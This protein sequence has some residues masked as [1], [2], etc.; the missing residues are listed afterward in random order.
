VLA[1]A[2][3]AFATLAVAVAYG[4]VEVPQPDTEYTPVSKSAGPIW[5]QV[6]GA[7]FPRTSVSESSPT[8]FQLD[9]FAVA[10]ANQSNG[11]AGGAE[12][13][14]RGEDV[15]TCERVPVIYQYS[16]RFG[17][18]RWE[19]IYR[20]DEKGFVGAIAWTA[21]GGAIAVGGT[22]EYTRQE[23]AAGAAELAGL[24]RVWTFDGDGWQ[25]DEALPA[26]TDGGKPMA[27]LTAV[28][29]SPR[30]ERFCVAGGLR[31]LWH[32]RGDR[33][34][35]SYEQTSPSDRFDDAASF[36]FRVRQIAFAPGATAPSSTP[37]VVAVTSGCCSAEAMQN[38][39]RLLMLQKGKWHSRLL[40]NDY[41]TTRPAGEPP[42]QADAASRSTT[43]DARGTQS[44]P[45]SYFSVVFQGS[46]SNRVSVLAAPARYDGDA[47]RQSSRVIGPVQLENAAQSM[48]VST[49]PTGLS[50]TVVGAAGGQSGP[51][52]DTA[53]SA[54]SVAETGSP[55]SPGLGGDLVN[56]VMTAELSDVRLVAGD[57]D[58]ASTQGRT[59]L[60]TVPTP[61][62]DG[63]LDWAVGG[64]PN[65]RGAAYTTTEGS[66]PLSDVLDCRGADNLAQYAG[67]NALGV[68]TC[69]AKGTDGAGKEL[70]SQRLVYLESYTLNAFDYEPLGAVAWAAGDR[71]ALV[72]FGGDGKLRSTAQPNLPE[73]GPP[74]PIAPADTSAYE[75]FRP[76]APEGAVGPVPP[77]KDRPLNHFAGLRLV[78]DGVPDPTRRRFGDPRENLSDI[79]MSRDGSEGWALGTADLA[80]NGVAL[81]HYDGE[82]WARCDPSGIADRLEADPACAAWAPLQ[83]QGASLRAAARVP[84]ERDESE[85]DDDDE[86][87]AVALVAAY[88]RP[89][90]T[91]GPA[92][93]RYRQGSWEVD[94]AMANGL[95]AQLS[96]STAPSLVFLAPNDG[97]LLGYFGRTVQLLH[98]DGEGWVD[99]STDPARTDECGDTSTGRLPLEGVAN[100]GL[101]LTRAGDRLYLYA[102]R[103]A[104]GSTAA[105]HP[106]ASGLLPVTVPL[107]LHK[108][109]GEEWQAEPGGDPAAENAGSGSQTIGRV[110]DVSIIKRGDGYVGW[111][112]GRFGGND[113]EERTSQVD[114]AR[115]AIGTATPLLRLEGGRWQ[116]VADAGAARD[117]V[118]RSAFGRHEILTI[119]GPGDKEHAILYPVHGTGQPQHPA[120][121]YREG[122]GWD[123]LPAPFVQKSKGEGTPQTVQAGVRAVA[124]DGRDGAW[125]VGVQ[126]VVPGT[127]TQSDEVPQPHQAPFFYRYADEQNVPVFDEAPHPV[128][129]PITATA[130]SPDGTLWVATASSTVYRYDRMTGWQRIAVGGW[131]PSI[132]RA[133]EANA[134]AVGPDGKGLIVGR[135]GRIAAVSP[136]T[137]VLDVAAGRGC[138]AGA[139]PCSTPHDLRAVAIATDGSAMAGGDG[140]SLL[141]R[142][143]SG[144]FRAVNT[145]RTAPTARI[146]SVVLPTPAQAFVA[147][148]LGEVFVGTLSGNDWDWQLENVDARDNLISLGQG[149]TAI[150]LRALAVDKDGRGYA[151]GEKGLILKRDPGAERPWQRLDLPYTDNFYSVA[152][153]P[154]GS[155]KALVGGGLGL[156]LTGSGDRFAVAR[157]S[158]YYDPLTTSHGSALAARIVGVALLRGPQPG[159]LE[160]WAASQVPPAA[161]ASRTPEPGAMLHYTNAP[162]EPLL[163]PARRTEPLP[164][165]P[166]ERPGELVF[167]AFGRGECHYERGTCPEPA[168]T[169][170]FN[171]VVTR[172]VIDELAADEQ[173]GPKPDFALI[174]GDIASAAGRESGATEGTGTGVSVNTPLDDDIMHRR[175]VEAFGSRLRDAGMPTFA[176]IGGKDLGPADACAAALARCHGTRHDGQG[177]GLSH[178]WRQAFAGM[179]EPWGTVDEQQTRDDL[180][181]VPVP[182]DSIEPLEAPGG[183]AKTHYAVDVKRGGQAVARIVVVDTSLR[184]LAAGEATQNPIEPRGGQSLWLERALCFRDETV[185]GGACSRDRAQQAIVLSNTPSYSYGPGANEDTL[186][187]FATFETTLMRYKTT[188]AVSGRLG[189]NGKYWSTAPGLHDPCPGGDYAEAPPTQQSPRCDGEASSQLDPAAATG[190]LADAMGSLGAPPPPGLDQPDA[191]LSKLLPTVIASSAGGR[192]GPDGSATGDPG[193]GYWH[194]YTKVRL[195]AS[196]D[197]YGV[198]VEQRP[199]L[200]WITITA[201]TH[202]LRAGQRVRLRGTGREPAGMDTPLRYLNIDSPA[203]TH[204]YDL[205]LADLEK[206]YLP[207]KDSNGDYVPLPAAVGTVDRNSG[208]V[209]AG[210]GNRERTY[211]IGILSV[212]QKATTYP[213]VFEPRRSFQ[214]ARARLV[215][216]PPL[217]P[218]QAGPAQQPIQ[219][220]ES[221]PPPP[222]QP[223]ANPASP[224]Q[225]QN[226]QAPL[227]PEF[228]ALPAAGAP[229]APAPPGIQPPPPVPPPPPP[230][231]TPP[232]QQPQSLAL[233]AKPVAVSVVPAV[234]PPAPPPVNP[235]PP[236]GSAARKEAKQR[237]AAVAKSEEGEGG[238]VNPEDAQARTNA[239]DS[240]NA[241]TRHEGSS[242]QPYAFTRRVESDR[243][244]AWE[245]GSLYG[246]ITVMMAM[247]MAF[248]WRVG[249][250]TPR[251][252]EPAAPAPAWNR[253]PPRR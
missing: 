21:D 155:G 36:R 27:A 213:L 47:V 135:Q 50:T 231:A 148:D 83:R 100:R 209:R 208:L 192:F 184:S 150:P 229:P 75:G 125:M 28:A 95:P 108:D 180:E 98:F 115:A 226:I 39:P 159:Q 153:A 43:R 137:V 58:F 212:G 111:A 93:L 110:V 133:S 194:G 54:L 210:R 37:E 144:D 127:R 227:P 15:A 65:A 174:T 96:P 6:A 199:V 68:L 182:D 225:T 66:S 71:G 122:Q 64:L 25:E 116:A 23:P 48:Q 49:T 134:I 112:V 234:N 218:A 109:P 221:A 251:R 17:E 166:S 201:Q 57:G 161:S 82:R 106:A 253:L 238:A 24:G 246:G 240:P 203:I 86:F 138:D 16:E 76:L 204:R 167:G 124:T 179:A 183:G 250:P 147:T 131:D 165:A 22:G 8:P 252:R 9:F 102:N 99:C 146:T 113:V 160:A 92:A 29:C 217:R 12:C 130:A 235:A 20:S 63:R 88:T 103:A 44:L 89:N 101:G 59:A 69:E 196:G 62:P 10:F 126:T 78:P 41:R 164:D 169:N 26:T 121:R 190:Q 193:D 143:G 185:P 34:E 14:N 140:R 223:P 224:L 19:E 187:D 51:A 188:V 1:A 2:V 247:M 18:G 85:S 214:P 171:E 45:D 152:L 120:L 114:A 222:A 149:R 241:A 129:E 186:T 242:P 67:E 77:L 11:F 181:F 32:W 198:I 53:S 118:L 70:Q 136:T 7:N 60:A 232:T 244:S 211:A 173:T 168:G 38:T 128:R 33:F 91:S 215:L 176:A 73:L 123:V 202:T 90:G 55:G 175:W 206:P 119:A 200:D 157:Q 84:L 13:R 249:R 74:E 237:Q 80:Q 245:T 30:E 105:V 79:V 107:I 117:Y 104:E 205:V 3:C 189:W 87:E 97:W 139:T 151:V 207:A 195:P 236:G 5:T 230:P 178:P 154:D 52:L 219:L 248:G 56:E 220:T 132:T 170:L 163:D 35:T 216:P 158:D 156:I 72:R 40:S 61:Q 46:Q 197:P 243:V 94:E 239:A 162:D 141:W 228:P 31:Q 142:P 172:R 177:A 191:G 145:P 81:H 233:G 4:Q 42:S